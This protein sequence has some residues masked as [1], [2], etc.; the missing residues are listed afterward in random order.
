MATDFTYYDLLGIKPGAT[1]EEIKRAYRTNIAK[2][3]PDRNDAPNANQLAGMMITAWETLQDPDRR[4]EYD[5]KIGLSRKGEPGQGF[6]G[7]T[8]E[9]Q[10]A[11]KEAEWRKQKEA[12][13]DAR[14]R[15]TEAERQRSEEEAA[16]QRAA[17]EEQR[18]SQEFARQR[19]AEEERQKQ[20][21]AA[22]KI[23][24]AQ[25][26]EVEKRRRQSSKTALFTLLA[27]AIGIIIFRTLNSPLT[28]ASSP[29]SGVV[30]TVQ[31]SVMQS[32]L[33]APQALT[34]VSDGVTS[35]VPKLTYQAV[36]QPVP[37][38]VAV[39]HQ[40]PSVLA[41]A[42]P[43]P[44]ISLGT[45]AVVSQGSES[46]GTVSCSDR[47]ITLVSDQGAT[48]ALSD[49]NSYAVSG[50]MMEGTAATWST[51]DRVVLCRSGAAASIANEDHYNLKIQAAYQGTHVSGAVIC[52]DRMITLVSDQGA[53]VAL[54]DGNSY[55]VSGLMM[56][57]TAATWSTGDR[58]VL[59]R[60]GAAASIANED[61]Y[62]LKIQ[63]AYQST[64][65]SE[66]V[67]CSD[68]M[69][70]Q[71]S[72]QGATVALSDGNSYAVA[73]LMMRGTAAT[74]STGDRVV[75]CRSGAAASIANEDHYGLKI[76]AIRQ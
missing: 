41:A 44:T 57:G 29:V 37:S 20:E 43:R 33:V 18:R 34:R 7:G 42:T 65:V 74:W 38:S 70:T 71:V 26:A 5:R 30:P 31:P 60:S 56:Q 4:T 66:A 1:H 6:Q 19:A 28:S 16:R 49:G 22:E 67:V 73:G 21:Q 64:H 69:I 52:S 27:I 17:A 13:A 51:G 50:L 11:Q 47:M 14:R 15:Q 61:H 36:T 75:L 63:A 23:R 45:P 35:P 48:V 12:E 54:S 10:R 2:Y 24:Q 39:S 8:R 40:T 72:D 68:R 76:Q 55:A 46:S 59:C 3:H 62:N 32:A 58:V 25:V 53:T 9:S